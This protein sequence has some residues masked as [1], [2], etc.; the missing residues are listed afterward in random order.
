M[1]DDR[2]ADPQEWQVAI[3]EHEQSAQE[4]DNEDFAV[5]PENWQTVR[6]FISL[7]NCFKY[8]G[9]SGR[10]TGISRTDIESALTM[11]AIR[12]PHKRIFLENLVAMEV[13]ALEVLN[14][15]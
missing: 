11:W 12:R 9:M 6:L 15:K 14:R 5:W 4:D 2:L 7:G 3:E 1:S 13:A 10:F 8:D